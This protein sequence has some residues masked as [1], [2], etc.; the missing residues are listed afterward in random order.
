[1]YTY[2]YI[3]HSFSAQ[4]NN[5]AQHAKTVCQKDSHIYT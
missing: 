2:I 4:V 3:T 5:Y 1:M